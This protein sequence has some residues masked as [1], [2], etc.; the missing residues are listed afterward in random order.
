MQII[1]RSGQTETFDSNKI[2]VVIAKA[3]ANVGQKLDD[4]QK[5]SLV[6]VITQRVTNAVEKTVENIQDIVEETLMEKGFYSVAKSFI[7]Y[8]QKLV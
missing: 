8:R 6:S 3:F 2:A 7:L 4:N 5:D 1:K